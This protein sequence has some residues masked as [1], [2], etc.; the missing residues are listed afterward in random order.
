MRAQLRLLK[1]TKAFLSA[2]LVTN[3]ASQINGVFSRL[4]GE[5]ETERD[6]ERDT[7]RERHRERER[8]RE[9]E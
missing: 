1:T 7:H 9:R 2:A 4:E 8:E 6:R 5:R 3:K